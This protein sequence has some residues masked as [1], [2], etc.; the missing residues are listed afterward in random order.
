MSGSAAQTWHYGL[1]ARWWAEFNVD[2]PEI[3]WFRPFVE[4]GQPALDAACGTGRLLI[5]YL[6]AGLDVDGVDISADMLAQVRERCEREGLAPPNVYAQALH[7]LDLPRRYRTIIVC[8]GF[9]LG[10]QRAHDVEGLRRL[11]EHLEPGGTLVL[12]N[13]VPYAKAFLWSYWTKEKRQEL[14]RQWRDEGDR[15]PLGD[16]TELELRSRL[17]ETDPLEQR[18]AIEM[19]AFHWRADE[20]LAEEQH[21]I[22]MTDYFTFELELLLERTGFVDIEVRGA[23]TDRSPTADD[24]FVVFLARKPATS[25]TAV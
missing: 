11:Y 1:V 10:G 6:H 19:R 9:G 24:D 17:V 5:P 18:V 15:R 23:L 21:R 20:L 7:Q 25:S 16:G 8:G 2:G 12:D 13:E 3:D 4:A 14:P 22:E